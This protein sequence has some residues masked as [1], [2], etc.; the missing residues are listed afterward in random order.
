MQPWR[1]G[2]SE[3]QRP[4]RV[5]GLRVEGLLQHRTQ[6]CQPGHRAS[7]PVRE[8]VV[9]STTFEMLLANAPVVWFGVRGMRMVLVRTVYVVSALIF[10][11]LGVAAMFVDAPNAALMPR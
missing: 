2:R 6:L 5:G 7:L 9:A 11:A 4:F 1:I 3:T 10:A 8:H